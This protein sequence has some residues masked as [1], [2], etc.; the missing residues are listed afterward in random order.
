MKNPV[1]FTASISQT[2]RGPKQPVP[3]KAGF[4]YVSAKGGLSVLNSSGPSLPNPKKGNMPAKVDLLTAVFGGSLF[5]SA[6]KRQQVHHAHRNHSAQPAPTPTRQV[7]AHLPPANPGQAQQCPAIPPIC[8]DSF[9]RV[10]A[11]LH[12][13]LFIGLAA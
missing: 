2:I 10:G 8:A 9:S 4:F 12:T 5:L 1:I 13:K 7:P 6:Y 11:V 3:Y